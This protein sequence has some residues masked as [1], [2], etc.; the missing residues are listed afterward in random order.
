MPRMRSEPVLHNRALMALLSM[1]AIAVLLLSGCACNPSLAEQ[2]VAEGCGT[3]QGGIIRGPVDHKRI[4]LAFTGHG[5]AEGA[6]TILK[7]LA[8]HHAHASF[9]LT[10]SFLTNRDFALL[11]KRM[12]REG[13]Y[14]GPHSDAHLLYCAWDAARKTLVT[15]EQFA[16]DL[17]ANAAKLPKSARKSTRFFLP[18]F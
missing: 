16:A 4:A 13:H 14:I 18:P 11:V 17:A 5:Y 8:R 7:E 3:W 12:D 6:D 10:G 1:F 9:F 15:R 2:K